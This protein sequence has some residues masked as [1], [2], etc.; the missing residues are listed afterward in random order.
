MSSIDYTKAYITHNNGKSLATIDE[1]NNF[2]DLGTFVDGEGNA[3][4]KVYG[5]AFGKDREIY[6]TQ[7]NG[8]DNN[9]TQI[10]KANLPA[11]GGEVTLN[12]IGTGLGTYGDNAINTHAMDI[13]PDGSMFILDLQGNIFTVDLSTGLANFVA[14]TV[15]NSTEGEANRRIQNAMDIVFDSNFTLY[16]QGTHPDPAKGSSLFTVNPSTGAA[17]FAGAFA[18]GTNIMGLWANSEG[19]I[20]ATKYSNPGNLYT[21]NPET[22]ALSLVGTEGDYGNNPHGGDQWIATVVGQGLIHQHSAP[23]AMTHPQVHS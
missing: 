21:V 17:T 14:E 13:G 4:D 22:A 10:W 1:N 5:L 11:V 6:L 2:V 20:F 7:Q 12:K 19:T 9:D 8:G 18:S 16:A 15:I 3:L 23:P